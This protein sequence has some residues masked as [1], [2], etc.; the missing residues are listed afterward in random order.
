MVNICS[1]SIETFQNANAILIL[2]EWDE[3]KQIDFTK[4]FEIMKKPAWIFDGR[5]ILDH[6]EL[7]TIGFEVKAIGKSL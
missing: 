3:F 7:K 6:Q 4:A 1:N 5:N 2:T